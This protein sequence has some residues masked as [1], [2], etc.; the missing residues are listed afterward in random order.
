[1]KAKQIKS[2]IIFTLL[3][4]LSLP[5]YADNSYYYLGLGIGNSQ[6]DLNKSNIIADDSRLGSGSSFT[7]DSTAFDFFGGI[8]LDQYL[9][10]EA[11]IL[12]AGDITATDAGRKFK[13]FDTSTLALTI[14]LSK[15]IGDGIRMFGKIGAHLWDISEGS[16]DLDTIDNAVDL[17]YGLGMDI[18]LY[19][20]LS[21]QMRIQWNH[22]EYDGIFIDSND[23]ISVSLLFLITSD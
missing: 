18:N 17:T 20:D 22:Y 21:R 5:T 2:S 3:M 9:S 12:L 4:V 16:S 23:T 8:Q 15:Q 6:F 10:L 1:M 14:A 13:L 19:G 11:D 7:D